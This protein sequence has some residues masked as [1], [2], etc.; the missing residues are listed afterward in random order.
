MGGVLLTAADHSSLLLMLSSAGWRIKKLQKRKKI[1]L[2]PLV[3]SIRRPQGHPDAIIFQQFP[4]TAGHSSF[5][6][7]FV[8]QKETADWSG[9][10]FTGGLI[11]ICSHGDY[12][13]QQDNVGMKQ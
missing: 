1:P 13:G 5:Y 9:T 4:K 11:H 6:Q 8:K 7:K 2:Q 12:L 3:A 10:I